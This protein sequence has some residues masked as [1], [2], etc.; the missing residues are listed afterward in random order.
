MASS[1]Y[2]Y[3]ELAAVA[4]GVTPTNINNVETLKTLE[5]KLF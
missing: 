5:N 4:S 1:N 3:S 2:S